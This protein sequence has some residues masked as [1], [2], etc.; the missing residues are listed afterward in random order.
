VSFVQNEYSIYLLE[1]WGSYKPSIDNIWHGAWPR[2]CSINALSP[3]CFRVSW[4]Y[5]HKVAN[6]AAFFLEFES[7]N[8]WLMLKLLDSLHHWSFVFEESLLD[9]IENFGNATRRGRMPIAGICRWSNVLLRF[10]TIALGVWLHLIIPDDFL[11]AWVHLFY[12][13][14]FVR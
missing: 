2:L 9:V 10:E 4:F 14:E 7:S 1:L 6:F 8:I 13:Q 11:L 5:V 12:L 3:F